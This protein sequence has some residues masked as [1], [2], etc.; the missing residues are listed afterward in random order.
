[1]GKCS[2]RSLPCL[3][4]KEGPWRAQQTHSGAEPQNRLGVPGDKQLKIGPGNV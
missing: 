1:M 2:V 3:R 4:A